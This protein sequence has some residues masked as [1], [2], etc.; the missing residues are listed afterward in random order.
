MCSIIGS[1][2]KDVIVD[3]V[4]LN[5]YRGQHSY[6]YSYYDPK[7]KIITYMRKDLGSIPV[8]DILVPEGQYCIAHMQ[9]PT[10]DNKSF[11]SIHPAI[12]G[13]SQSCLWHNGIVKDLC[14]KDMMKGLKETNSWDTYLILKQFEMQRTL[15]GIDGTF[16]CLYYKAEEGLKLFR[17][18][19]SPM[20]FDNDFNISSTKFD[21]SQS[22]E[23]NIVW[24]F[25]PGECIINEST[26]TTVENP[27]FFMDV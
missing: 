5:L 7:T 18:E 20:F 17:N 22:L 4:K 8:E 15:N 11:N 13:P 12:Y 26:F 6:S 19:I 24:N 2:N 9:A 16:S 23:P 27:Y 1:F 25:I 10:T 3:L 14:V 21:N